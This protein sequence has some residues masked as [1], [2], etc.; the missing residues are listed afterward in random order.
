L[1]LGAD[2]S[3]M[4]VAGTNV[5]TVMDNTGGF[6]SYGDASNYIRRSG[7]SLDIRSTNFSLKTSGE[8]GLGA[9]SFFEGDGVWISDDDYE[10][11]PELLY[12]WGK[13]RVGNANGSRMQWNDTDLVIYNSSNALIASFGATNTIAGWSIATN[14]LSKSSLVLNA[15]ATPYIALGATS[16]SA[17]DG[18]WLATA[19]STKF[20]VGNAGAAR[21][22]WDDANLEFYNNSNTLVASFG[23]INSISSFTFTQT[24]FE[25]R[26]VSL[27]N[28]GLIIKST[29]SPSD[30]GIKLY[31]D[32]TKYLHI[33]SSSG[34][35][36]FDLYAHNHNIRLKA[37]STVYIS[38]SKINMDT[39]PT[40][41]TGLSTGDVFTQ[42]ATQLGGSGTTKVL[43][44]F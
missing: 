42:T 35:M 12:T 39:I 21:M 4:T 24:T 30:Y 27:T 8:I 19:A 33:D 16:Y 7:T 31:A 14:Q 26:S 20:R 3:G 28:E 22:Q 38:G 36:F 1:A 40:A 29:K 13:F 5:G 25:N 18:V 10:F 44:I 43:C 41:S 9:T 17:G 23:E 34:L 6:L 11:N 32:I 37:D 2:A 15:S